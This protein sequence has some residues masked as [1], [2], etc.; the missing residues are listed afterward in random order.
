VLPPGANP[1]K[2]LATKPGVHFESADATG[3]YEWSTTISL[4]GFNQN[5][6]GYTSMASRW[7]TWPMATA[8]AC[9]S[10]AR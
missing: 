7:A 9:T 5:R 4:R 8:T 6:L 2:L 1:L 10:A 3:A